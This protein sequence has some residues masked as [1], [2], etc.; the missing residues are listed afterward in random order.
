MLGKQAQEGH[1]F[2]KKFAYKVKFLTYEK[3]V[4]DMV[5]GEMYYFSFKVKEEILDIFILK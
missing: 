5:R 3:N 2:E 4:C 1:I